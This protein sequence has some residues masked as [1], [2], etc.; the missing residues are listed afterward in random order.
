MG[1]PPRHPSILPPYVTGAATGPLGPY[2]DLGS[3]Q[4]C[5]IL[6][7]VLVPSFFSALL[8]LPLFSLYRVI[9]PSLQ[10]RQLWSSNPSPSHSLHASGMPSVPLFSGGNPS[11]PKPYCSSSRSLR[12]PWPYLLSHLPTYVPLSSHPYPSSVSSFLSLLRPWND[13]CHCSRHLFILHFP[14]GAAYRHSKATHNSI[15][16]I[17]IIICIPSFLACP[18]SVLRPFSLILPSIVWFFH[19]WVPYVDDSFFGRSYPIRP[20]SSSHCYPLSGP[21]IVP[22]VFSSFTFP[23]MSLLFLSLF[24]YS[25]FHSLICS[26][27]GSVPWCRWFNL[28]PVV[29]CTSHDSPSS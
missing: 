29:F 10:S 19:Y 14:S 9:F 26:L 27:F 25:F 8:F 16:L 7:V 3:H 18:S 22:S 15:S 20:L 17:P 13:A 23:Y 21:L 4:Y 12:V 5:F 6:L 28:L 2:P 11:V 24:P 1:D